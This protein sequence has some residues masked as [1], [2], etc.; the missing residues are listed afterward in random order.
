[1]HAALLQISMK[2]VA[3]MILDDVVSSSHFAL[4]LVPIPSTTH[5]VFQ[6]LM[7]RRHYQYPCSSKLHKIA[8]SETTI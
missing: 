3:M 8:M 7:T 1:M 2:K 6:S 4:C 5:E